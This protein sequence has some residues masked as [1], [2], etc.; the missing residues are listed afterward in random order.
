[1]LVAIGTKNPVKIRAVKKAFRKAFGG[2]SFSSV[3][4]PSGVS[5][6]PASLAETRV[7]AETRARHA[8]EKTKGADFGVGVEGGVQK[9]GDGLML[10]GYVVIIGKDGKVGIGGGTELVLPG[11]Y[12]KRIY[13]GEELGQINDDVSGEKGTKHGGGA[14][15]FLTKG[16]ATR[17]EY[18]RLATAFA[19]APFISEEV[20]SA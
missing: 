13:R 5:H 16:V 2:G 4:S 18:F 15:G 3:E 11:A 19:L 20:Y 9:T 6:T 7:G 12:A 10:C 17:E 1:M 8:L 14:V